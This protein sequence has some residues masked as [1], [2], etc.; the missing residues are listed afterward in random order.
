[1]GSI[2]IFNRLHIF[3]RG[4][5]LINIDGFSHCEASINY[6]WLL[7][8]LQ[9]ELRPCFSRSIRSR[10]IVMSITP[11]SSAVLTD[12]TLFDPALKR[13]QHITIFRIFA[14]FLLY[15]SIIPFFKSTNSNIIL[16]K[17]N[18]IFFIIDKEKSLPSIR[19][20]WFFLL[21]PHLWIKA[22][23]WSLF[24]FAIG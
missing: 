23:N 2:P 9:Y 5:F 15:L 17:L 10:Q 21:S 8:N 18:M 12:T 24:Y 6:L 14:P 3:W 19:K 4:S 13:F 22:Q 7:A 20:L 16:T 11:K 1:M